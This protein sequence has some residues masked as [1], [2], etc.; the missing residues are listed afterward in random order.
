VR[1]AGAAAALTLENQR[2][3]AELRAR[4]EDSWGQP[5]TRRT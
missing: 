2:L 1:A 5:S 3:A 4:I